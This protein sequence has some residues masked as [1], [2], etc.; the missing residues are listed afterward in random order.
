M[1]RSFFY[2]ILFTLTLPLSAMAQEGSLDNVSVAPGE[3]VTVTATIDP[4]LHQI[5]GWSISVVIVG[6]GGAVLTV[7]A[8]RTGADALAQFNGGFELTRVA[9]DSLGGP[10]IGMVNSVVL[11]FTSRV[12]L[13][14]GV[15]SVA[16]M[17]VAVPCSVATATVF[18]VVFQNGMQG[19]GQPVDNGLTEEGRLLLFSSL[20]SGSITV[21]GV[22][23]CDGDG[24]PDDEDCQP[25]SDLSETVVIDG[26]DSGVGNILFA[27]G[28]TISDLI[29]D[30]ADGA[31]NHGQFVSCVAHL[32][33]D[34]RKSGDI[35]NQDA[36]LIIVCAA[37]SNLP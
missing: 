4:E 18:P 32:V 25:D 3:T 19:P 11:S 22:A 30:C 23:D 10:D 7:P 29:A 13:A 27:D 20:V 6:S 12:T 24:V 37:Q 2:A 33:K 16:E 15:N 1:N 17:D 8:V 26:C 31:N 35:S 28:C 5:Q 9:T 34:L 21:V 14:S 36:A